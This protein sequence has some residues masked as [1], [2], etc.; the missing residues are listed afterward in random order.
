MFKIKTLYVSY[1]LFLGLSG[2]LLSGDVESFLGREQLLGTA[3]GYRE[4]LEEQGFDFSLGYDGELWSNVH[5]GLKTGTKLMGLAVVDATLDM[6]KIVGWEGGII[7]AGGVWYQGTQPTELLIGA[8]ES[9]AV[10]G[11]EAGSNFWRF[12][13]LYVEQR[14]ADDALAIRAGQ[15]AADET[16]MLSDYAELFL[17]A[18]FGA[19]P[20]IVD[21]V[22]VPVYPLPGPGV[23][24]RWEQEGGGPWFARLG[25]YTADAGADESSNVGFGWRLGGDAGAAL[26]AEG[27]RAISPAGRSG[28][29]TLGYF[30]TNRMLPDYASGGTVRGF[31]TVYLLVDQALWE[32]DDGSPKLGEFWRFAYNPQSTRSVQQYYTDL[33]LNLFQPFPGRPDDVAGLAAGWSR[34]YGHYRSAQEAAGDPV[35]PAQTVIELTYA[36]QV[37]PWLQ[38]QP[39]FQV[40]IDPAFSGRN[41]WVLGLRASLVF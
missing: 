15:L 17:N 20:G 40:Y 28:R 35:T 37:T 23:Y 8:E 32:Q 5:G 30:G 36:A 11:I 38:V 6:G 25:L 22:N 26:F 4:Q 34:Y 1:L 7:H 16:F 29:V 31:N 13:Q 12:Y 41:A 33:G 9:S 2:S 3:G 14:F 27:G 21:N 39:D 10:S 19:M 24:A 18:Q